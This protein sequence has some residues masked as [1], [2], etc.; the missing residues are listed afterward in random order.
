M[1]KNK[2][3]IKRISKKEAYIVSAEELPKKGDKIVVEQLDNTL[4]VQIAHKDLSTRELY[5]ESTRM[6]WKIISDWNSTPEK[7]G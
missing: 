3:L 7:R 2:E 4:S 5:V 1:N 6:V